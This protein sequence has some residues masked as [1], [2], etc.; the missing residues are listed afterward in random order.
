VAR[1]IW[2][3]AALNG[4]W[5]RRYQPN[6][7][8]FEHEIIAAGIACAKAGAAIIHVHAYDPATGRQRDDAD[9]YSR[10]IEGIRSQV[11]VLV[12]PTIPLAGSDLSGPSASVS[13]RFDHIRILAERGLIEMTVVDPGSV[14]FSARAGSGGDLPGF[15]YVN[16]E[17]EIAEGLALSARHGLRPSYAIYEAGFIRLGA[18]LAADGFGVKRPLYRLMFSDSFAW[19]FP[20]KDFALDAYLALL[21]IEAPAAPWM[22][23]GLRVDLRNLIEPAVRRGGHVRAGLEDAPFS[24]VLDNVGLVESAVKYIREAGGEPA[25][26]ADIRKDA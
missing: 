26:A 20:P 12:Y 4:P 25:T 2:V 21:E 11:D 7:P 15:V 19:G 13:G 23:A 18:A 9:I 24:C 17:A 16:S 10:I 6:I 1:E 5:G 22:I 14:N 8:V 3:E